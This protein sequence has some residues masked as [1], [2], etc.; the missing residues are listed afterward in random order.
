MEGGGEGYCLPLFPLV[1]TETTNQVFH[2]EMLIP[3]TVKAGESKHARLISVDF[4]S[5]HNIVDASHNDSKRLCLLGETV[6]IKPPTP[7]WGHTLRTSWHL[8]LPKSL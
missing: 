4:V 3:M 7:T 1:T 5:C 8:S 6:W 2:K